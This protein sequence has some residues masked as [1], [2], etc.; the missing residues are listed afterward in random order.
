MASD[1]NTVAISGNLTRDPEVR[2]TVLNFDIASNERRKNQQTGEWEDVPNFVSCVVFGNRV[3]PLSGILRKGMK[4]M[5]QGH[6]RQSS[7]EKDG[8][9]RS[10][11]EV[12]ADEVVLPPMGGQ[13]Q[14]QQPQQAPQQQYQAPQARQQFYPNQAPMQD[15]YDSSDIPF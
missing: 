7:W 14:Y 9:R 8:Q 12:V 4:V 1:I 10:K 3:Q 13:R 2:G 11:V 5:V 6:L 15:V